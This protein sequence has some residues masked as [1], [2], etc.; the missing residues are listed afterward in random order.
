MAGDPESE[1][2]FL[3]CCWTPAIQV[4]PAIFLSTQPNAAQRA[5]QPAVQNAQREK[6]ACCN[7]NPK[8]GTGQWQK[9]TT[10]DRTCL[11]DLLGLVILGL[12]LLAGGVSAASWAAQWHYLTGGI[13]W[14]LFAA[15]GGDAKR[16]AWPLWV[17]SRAHGVGLV[18]T[19]RRAW[20]HGSSSSLLLLWLTGFLHCWPTVPKH[21]GTAALGVG[22]WSLADA[23]A[24]GKP[25]HQSGRISKFIDAGSGIFSTARGD[26]GRRRLASLERRVPA[27]HSPL[28]QMPRSDRPALRGNWRIRDLRPLSLIGRPTRTH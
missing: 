3:G 21:F 17:P 5:E 14:P 7:I 15:A 19:G 10:V 20:L 1:R 8:G 18:A 26:A 9:V 27:T 23:A 2:V 4:W 12:A 11:L 13:D 24:V 22:R 25:V 16:Q 6:Q 28:K